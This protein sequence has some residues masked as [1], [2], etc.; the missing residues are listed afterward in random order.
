MKLSGLVL[1]SLLQASSPAPVLE[2]DFPAV[3]VGVAEY[4]DGPTGATVFHFRDPV[5]AAVD[6]RGGAPGTIN[7]DALRL[8]YDT[9]YVNAVA[10]AGGS[11]YGLAAATGVADAIKNRTPNAGDWDKIATVAGAIIFDLGGRRYS[12][13]APDDE[14]GRAAFAA[15]VEGRFPL[16]ARGAGRFAMQG[17]YFDDPQHSGQGG[18]FFQAGPTKVLVFTVVNALGAVVDRA[19][20]VVRCRDPK[21][22]GCGAVAERLRAK[23]MELASI[24]REPASQQGLSANTTITL[25]ITNQKLPF[26][27]LQR[28]AVQVHNSMARAIQPFG[29][30]D[31]GDTLFAVTTGE[32]DNPRLPL[33]DL[34]TLASE[35]AWD[36]VL[37][38]VP[39][40]PSPTRAAP[41]PPK[42]DLDA[43]AGEYELAPGARVVVKREGGVLRIEVG[44]RGSLYLPKGGVVALR[45]VAADEFVLETPRLDRIRFER[46]ADGTMGGFVINPGPWPIPARRIR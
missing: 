33:V 9:P 4:E 14:L 34:A 43:C 1:A 25:V 39:E 5:T 23:R 3:R 26:W 36:A 45:Q 41:T 8:S 20:R 42:E 17:W 15:A 16:G 13:R 38:S 35:V 44:E 28:L 18:A 21:A 22:E 19:G 30:M 11:S 7:T 31:D 27:A 12:T 10:F 37:A 40:I 2:F 32:V 29:T 6:V 24:V 46:S